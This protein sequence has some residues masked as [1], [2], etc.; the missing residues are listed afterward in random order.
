[1]FEGTREAGSAIAPTEEPTAPGPPR[2]FVWGIQRASG[3]SR[4]LTLT[5]A[6][7]IRNFLPQFCVCVPCAL[8]APA[9]EQQGGGGLPGPAGGGGCSPR[10][11]PVCPGDGDGDAAARTAVPKGSPP[12][13]GSAPGLPPLRPEPRSGARP[14]QQLPSAGPS[15]QG[16]PREPRY[17]LAGQLP[18]ER[19]TNPAAERG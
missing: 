8:A 18:A 1:M 2:R 3:D 12:G 15:A 10:P 7:G 14:H 19:G 17:P 4:P 5:R 11:Q 6:R 13:C 9:G 16:R